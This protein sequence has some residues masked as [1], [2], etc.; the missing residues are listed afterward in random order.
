MKKSGRN[1]PC[2]CG[3]GNKYKRCCLPRE[4]DAR[5][6][7]RRREEI[8]DRL[9]AIKRRAAEQLARGAPEAATGAADHAPEVTTETAKKEGQEAK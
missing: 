4:D 2:P 9:E 1:D 7:V 3:S 5:A 6:M 8:L